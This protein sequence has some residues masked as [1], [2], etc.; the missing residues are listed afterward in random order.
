MRSGRRCS[1][2]SR[3]RNTETFCRIVRMAIVRSAQCGHARCSTLW[4]VVE[5]ID[6]IA[7]DLQSLGVAY[8]EVQTLKSGLF[9]TY[10]DV[11]TPS[12]S[13]QS[14]AFRRSVEGSLP[15]KAGA[16]NLIDQFNVF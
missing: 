15:R 14:S 5:K 9:V 1:T 16:P 6:V 2:S 8:F 3:F 7:D 4:S 13:R 11:A 10:H 12:S